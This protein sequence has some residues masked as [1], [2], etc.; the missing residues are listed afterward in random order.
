V[1]VALLAYPGWALYGAYGAYGYNYHHPY[2]YYNRT[3]R[4]N[5]TATRTTS[6]ATATPTVNGKRGVVSLMELV[7]RQAAESGQNETKPI[8]CL[9]AQ[10]LVCGCDDNGDVSFLNA[11]IGDGDYNKLNKTLI[12][13]A[14]INGTSTIIIN[15]TLPNGT[16]AP[17]GVDDSAAANIRVISLTG[18]LVMVVMVGFT[19]FMI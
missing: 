9:C 5:A 18:Y 3:A 12:N 4:R 10:Y 16:T 6:S 11:L 14:D 17:G 13:V 7:E 15:G 8:T 1:G 2:S 19:C